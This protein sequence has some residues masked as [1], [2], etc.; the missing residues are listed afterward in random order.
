MGDAS[1]LADIS[2]FMESPEGRSI[3][4]AVRRRFE[5]KSIQSV[6]FKDDTPYIAIRLLFDDGS[7]VQCMMLELSLYAIRDEYQD[8]LDREYRAERTRTGEKSM[9]QRVH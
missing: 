9:E 6:L 7:R 8:V 4:E 2:R 3:L 1:D 5:G